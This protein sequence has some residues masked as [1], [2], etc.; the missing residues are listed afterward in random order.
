MSFKEGDILHQ[1]LK[2]AYT[3]ANLNK[4]SRNL[5]RLYVEKQ[6]DQLKKIASMIAPWVTIEI[7]GDKKGFSKLIMLY[8]PD[9]IQYYQNELR[10]FLT[11]KSLSR[12]SRLEH[13]LMILDIEEITCLSDNFE[14]IDYC[15]EYEWDEDTT[16][17]SY[18]SDSEPPKHSK[19]KNK[20][21]KCSYSFYDA[22][23]I[24]N[25]GNTTTE[26][27]TWYFKDWD[28]IELM[29]SEIDD[30][31]G[32]QYCINAVTVDLS[33]NSITD[34]S[35]IF[36]LTEIQELN[37]SDNKIGYIDALSNLLK[38]KTVDLSNNEIDDI[39]PLFDLPEL[40]YCDVS[41]NRLSHAQVHELEGLGVSVCYD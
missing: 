35:P 33:I 5:I 41:G 16:G 25:Y 38:L 31:D 3:E 32:I 7:D 19:Q 8:H 26:I 37:L 4:I 27:P 9:R 21:S 12:L 23:K 13:I 14:D 20:V 17:F 30:L 28:E 36:D 29:D 24:R 2:A 6:F 15:A 22:V 11:S 34:I 18:F 1:Q 40:E 10:D 39:S